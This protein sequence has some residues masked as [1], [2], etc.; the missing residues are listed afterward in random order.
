MAAI[1]PE[2]YQARRARVFDTLAA[3]G[4]GVAVLF[5]APERVRSRDVEYPYRADSYLLY[6]TG[7]DEPGAALVLVATG[8]RRE[9]LLYCRPRDAD[10]EIWDGPRHGPEAAT[11]RF[12]CDAGHPIALLDESLPPLL[13]DAPAVYCALARPKDTA[14]VQGWLTAVR[15]MGRRGVSAPEAVVDLLPLL[16]AMRL[17]K[18]EA[19]I[20]TLRRAAAITSA[21]H[22]RLLRACRPG[23][24]EVELEAELLHEFVRHGAQPAYPAIVAAG[25]NACILHYPA[26]GAELRAGDLCLVDAGCEV[27]GYASDVT[28]TFPVAGR[29][30]GEQRAVYEIVLAAQA[31]AIAAVR[32]GARFNAPHDAATRVLT[33]GLIDLG[34]LDGSLDGALESGAYKAYYM[35]RTSHF[36]GLDVHDVGDTREGAAPAEGERPWRTLEPG[37]VLTVEPGLYLRGA[38]VQRLRDIGVRIEDDVRVTADG[39]EVLTTAA[40]QAADVEALMR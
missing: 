40:K 23:Q 38:P 25:A 35:H 33:Q 11:T 15:A 37:M 4:G 6:L 27:D 29:F 13:A 2:V 8:G 3:R 31:A 34:V 21:A 20:A 39:H 12:G 10:R 17:V 24:R 36:L 5:A 32:P 1:D 14:R 28:R 30:S 16:D 26:G 18:D 9:S 19:E 22:E 7:F